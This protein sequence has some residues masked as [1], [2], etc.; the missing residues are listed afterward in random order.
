MDCLILVAHTSSLNC[1]IR[2]AG[3]QTGRRTGDGVEDGERHEHKVQITNMKS[4]L[5]ILFLLRSWLSCVVH[6]HIFVFSSSRA[7]TS[8]CTSHLQSA[9][10]MST[11]SFKFCLHIFVAWAIT[12]VGV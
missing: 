5:R 6:H 2:K 7:S 10:S 12:R 3:M 11:V 4:R 8:T 1:K 9:I